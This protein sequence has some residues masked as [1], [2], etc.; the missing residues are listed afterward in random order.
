M[1]AVSWITMDWMWTWG[2]KCFGYR[3]GDSLFSYRGQEVGRFHG[4]EI[5]G[6][7]GRYLGEVI[8]SNR[9]ITN[10][11]KRG[12]IRRRLRLGEPGDMPVM[13]T[14]RGTRCTPA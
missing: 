3:D 12:W 10:R 8:N 4:N 9:L 13:R 1:M 6:P 2:G 7:N 5:Y 14:M 11:A